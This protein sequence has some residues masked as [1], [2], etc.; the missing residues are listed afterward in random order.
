MA[1]LSDETS[2][3]GQKFE[4]FHVS[5][6]DGRMYVLGLRDIASKSGQ[7]VLSTFQQ[8]LRDIE[9]VSLQA[10]SDISKKILL[11]ITTTMSDRASTQIK[12]NDLL[13]EYRTEILPQT[14]EN[15]QQLSEAERLSLGKLCNFF[16]GLHA[17]VHLAETASSSLLEAQAGFFEQEAPIMDKS[18]RKASE[19]GTTRLVR[20]TCKAVAHGGDEKSGCHGS[21]LEF[22]RP[23]LKQEGFGGLPLEPFRGNRFNILFRN[24]ASILY[25]ADHLNEY[26][27]SNANNK[28]LKA[29]AFDLRVPEY[30]AGCKALGLIS[31]LV[32]VPL[33]SC[34]E[35]RSIHLM[36][37]GSYYQEII[38]FLVMAENRTADFMNGDLRLSFAN[39]QKLEKDV[40]FQRL[41]QTDEYDEKVE[42]ILKIMLPAMA[43]LMQRIFADHLQGGKWADASPETREKT[44]GLPKHNK[45]SES[46]FAHLDRLL[47]EKPNITTIASEAY[48]MFAHNRTSQWL[49]AKSST[50]KESIFSSARKSVT[51]VRKA[52]KVRQLEIREA[53]RVAVAEKLQ[54]AEE[55]RAKQLRKKEQQTSDIIHWGLWQ[56]NMISKWMTLSKPL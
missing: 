43:R 45:F 54:K 48:V 39:S 20:T 26:L 19:P 40:I 51:K 33:W 22:L 27:E 35:D 21:F 4:G 10:S 55:N 52:F 12:F 29:V 24:A 53:R 6:S 46:I 28:L 38:D 9:D 1:L 41:I 42:T 47:R 36:D 13:E 56:H 8:I 7:D 11:N 14:V 34:I 32:T 37:I 44:K 3:F 49:D 50:E 15:Y 5:D 25:L 2:K 23:T 16:C 31:Y 17:L 18:F 30:I